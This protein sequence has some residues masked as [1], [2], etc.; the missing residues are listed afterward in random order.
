MH[1]HQNP[2]EPTNREWLRCK[3]EFKNGREKIASEREGCEGEK[4]N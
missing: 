4:G 3:A 2:S 1:H